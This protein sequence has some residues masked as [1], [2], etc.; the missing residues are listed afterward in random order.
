MMCRYLI[1]LMTR[2]DRGHGAKASV[3]AEGED[4]AGKFTEEATG[5][6]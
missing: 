5:S 2:K 6:R 4:G 3:H 1:Y